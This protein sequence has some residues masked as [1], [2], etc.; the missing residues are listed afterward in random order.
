M[1]M[2]LVNRA[3]TNAIRETTLLVK[4]A[5]HRCSKVRI[6]RLIQHYAVQGTKPGNVT[7][8]E[9][10]RGVSGHSYPLESNSPTHCS[11]LKHSDLEASCTPTLETP[12]LPRSGSPSQFFQA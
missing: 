1:R 11:R 2:T 3:I 8:Y 6:R 12:T 5:H 9:H 4:P 7:P 10:E